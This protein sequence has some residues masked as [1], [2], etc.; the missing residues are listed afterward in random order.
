MENCSNSNSG[1]R[2]AI[3]LTWNKYQGT[4]NTGWKSELANF[5][6]LPKIPKLNKFWKIFASNSSTSTISDSTIDFENSQKQRKHW[7]VT[8]KFEKRN[9]LR[10]PEFPRKT[11]E[12]TITQF[13]AKN[14]P[15]KMAVVSPVGR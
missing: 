15:G 1:E 10:K 6:Q 5:Q 9:G 3:N 7:D 13:Y 14:A 12:I 2:D 8:T 4:Q 11:L